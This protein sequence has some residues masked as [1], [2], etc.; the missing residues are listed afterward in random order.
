MR[1]HETREVRAEGR[2]DAELVVAFLTELLELQNVD[3]FLARKIEVERSPGPPRSV[4]ARL[5]GEPF[6][7]DRH[8]PRTEVK[9]IT[10]H[11][12]LFDP[13]RGRARVIVDI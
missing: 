3:G 13:A 10:Y 4:T 11:D 1:P 9:A 8:R 5:H 2:D 6:D 12:L 7:P